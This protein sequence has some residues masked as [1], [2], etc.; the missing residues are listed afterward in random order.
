MRFD[1]LDDNTMLAVN[2]GGGL[3]LYDTQSALDLIANARYQDDCTGLVIHK[4]DIIDDF[5]DLSTRIAGEA[6]QKFV[7]YSMK[8]AIVGNFEGGSSSLRDFIRESNRGNTVF[9][10]ADIDEAKA[11]LGSR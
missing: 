11:K 6:L 3:L 7:N 8:L 9:F 10:V 4:Q 2:E 5:F 1:K